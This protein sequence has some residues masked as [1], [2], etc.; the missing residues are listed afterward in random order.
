MSFIDFVVD[1]MWGASEVFIAKRKSRK[2]E[3]VGEAGDARETPKGDD[4][5][6]SSDSLADRQKIERIIGSKTV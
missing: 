2:A 3:A 1:L 6:A 5:A 4:P